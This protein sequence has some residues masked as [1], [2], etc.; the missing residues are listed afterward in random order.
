MLQA[1]ADVI[2]AVQGGFI[3]AW[4]E[5]HTSSNKLTTPANKA[6]VRD[7]LLQAVPASRQLQVRYPGDLAAWFPTPPTLEQLLAPSPTAAARIGQH[8][9]CFLASPDDVGTYWASTP[10]PSRRAAHL[11]PA[12]QRHHGR[13]GETCAPPVAAQARM[14]CEDILREG[15]A[16]HMTYL[17]RDYYEGFFAQWQAGGCMAEVSR[18][19][20][21]RLQL[22]TVTHG[23]V[24][25]PGG[26]LA[27]Q[28]SLS[29]QGWAR[30]LN[31]RNL[32]LTLVSAT[33]EATVLPLAGTDLRQ[34]SPGEPLQWRARSPCPPPWPRQLPRA[35]RC[36]RCRQRTGRHPRLCRALCQCRQRRDGRAV[37]G[38]HGAAGVGY[39]PA[40]AVTGFEAK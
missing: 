7:A 24:A 27:W 2:A 26:S 23:A 30:P 15:A 20:G 16:Y 6:A 31:A 38:E 1:N 40:G 33:N 32:A 28:V 12:S 8:N 25:T 3:G 5:W 17:N 14:T 21:Y 4:G 11:C 13:G 9:D 19:L 34:A 29:N 18:K 22:Q 35:H 10:Q 39:D 37:A 36:A